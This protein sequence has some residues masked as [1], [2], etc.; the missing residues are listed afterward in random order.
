MALNPV[1]VYNY[2][3]FS[4]ELYW[5]SRVIAPT[6]TVDERKSLSE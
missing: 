6:A 1:L 5:F 4:S 2:Q 3:P